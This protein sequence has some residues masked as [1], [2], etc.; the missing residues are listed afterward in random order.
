MQLLV[1]ALLNDDWN[2][3]NLS[4]VLF[5]TTAEKIF[6]HCPVTVMSIRD[7]SHSRKPHSVERKG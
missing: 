3:T 1:C 4:G 2:Q 6:R 7:V 5:G